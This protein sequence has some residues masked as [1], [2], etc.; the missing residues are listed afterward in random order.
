GPLLPG[1]SFGGPSVS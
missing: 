1:Q